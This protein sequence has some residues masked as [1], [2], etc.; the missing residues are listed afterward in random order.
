MARSMA[1]DEIKTE[2]WELG[3]D[4]P[5]EDPADDAY[6][7]AP[8]AS[9]LAAAI[10]GNKS[11]QGLV[12]AVHGK[13]GSGKSSLL[14]FI[15]HELRKLPEER[16]AVIVDFNPWWFEG[17]EQIAT[18]LLA[19][20]S[21]QLPDKLKYARDAAKLIGKYSK[22]IADAAAT[23]SGH[24]WIKAPVQWLANYFPKLKAFV[25]PEGVPK[26]KKKVAAALK[27]S[28]KRFVFFV[29][30]IDRLTPD[31]ARDFFRA[32][33]ALADFPEV[34]YVLF[35]GREEVA[36]ALTA[37]L[38]MDG[39]AYLEKIVQA[40][41]HL[42]AVDNQQLQQKLFKGLD[43]II[44]AHPMPFAF[45][46][47]RWAEVFSNGLDRLIKKPRDIVRVLNAISVAY[48][49]VAGEVNPVDFIALEFL[50]VFETGVYGS[51]REA[52]DIFCGAP[53]QLEYKNVEEKA[54][55]EAW[56]KALPEAS[57]NQLA[58]LIGRLFPKVS[59]LL[60]ISS[61]ATSDAGDWRKELRPCSPD[62]FDVYFQ[63][64][65][66]PGHVSR[67]ELDRL[68][69]QRTVEG[70]A[71]MML[72][73]RTVVFPDGHSK[74]RDLVDRL[75]DLDNLEP[76]QAAKLIEALVDTGYILLRKE[77][78]RSGFFSM[79]NRWRLS[80]LIS[81]QLERL[82]VPERQALLMRL[83]EASP[84][85]WS[86]VDIAD[87]VLQAKRAPSKA[88]HSMLGLD[89]GFAEALTKAV[90]QR[91]DHATLDQLM[92]MPDLDFIV[93]RWAIWGN[94]TCIPEV[95]KPLMQSDDDLLRLIDKFVR[96]GTITSGRKIAE[97]YQL[98]MKPLAAVM[99]VQEIEPRVRAL[100]LRP[101]LSQRQQTVLKRFSQGV[102]AIAEGKDPDEQRFMED[103]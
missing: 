34:V 92:A 31:E 8:F 36:K 65:V 50:R 53:S 64:G 48:P 18:Q 57:R 15:K 16:R 20:F 60:G 30:D 94:P 7:Y 24:S 56:K 72:D 95:F 100:L 14:N 19:E 13:W 102:Q 83:A 96:T 101:G 26:V 88:P 3:S 17:R 12:L 71:S 74:A 80:G 11:P 66:P 9:R 37:S 47:D 89:D 87:D 46:Q 61:F 51:V 54:Y 97:T 99:D 39:E 2:S 90:G 35:F 43:S 10:V 1:S 5:L 98:S 67:I 79:P 77:D 52:K 25:E 38:K 40:P 81:R 33:K 93:H 103:E 55:F 82:S 44:N 21:S 22:E 69:G 63:F 23:Y 42:P 4:L 41:F 32:I 86:L 70:M 76:G 73:A 27:A 78:E 45:D 28:G 29:D 75:R 62:N 68:A 59:Q 91:L 6:G 58:D 85:L 84:G 49:P